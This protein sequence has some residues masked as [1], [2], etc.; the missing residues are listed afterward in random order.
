MHK[1]T[2]ATNITPKVREAVWER[3]GHRCIVCGDGRAQPNSH[4][5]RRSQGGLGVEQNIVTHCRRCHEMYDLRTSDAVRQETIDY[6]K[7]IYPG[8]TEEQVTYSK[9][10]D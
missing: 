7:R 6:I 5:I 10:T 9:W 1:R 4:I 2:K 8:W 3:D